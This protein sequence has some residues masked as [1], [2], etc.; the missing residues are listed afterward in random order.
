MEG[1]GL[2]GERLEHS[3]SPRIHQLLG[4]YEYRLMPVARADLPAFFARRAFRGINVTIPYKEAVIPY[5]DTLSP[6]ARAIG[7]VNTILQDP[8]G[9]LHGYNTD[10]DGFMALMR[11]AGFAAAGRKCLVLGSGGASKTVRACLRDLGAGEVVVIS[12]TGADNY[13][14]IG[15]HAD[16]QLIVNATPVGMYP[17]NGRA[18]LSLAGFRQLAG[19]VDLIYNPLRT[20]LLLEA[21]RLGI[22]CVNGLHMLVAQAKRAGE[23]FMG[24]AIGAGEV[25]RVRRTVEKEMSNIVLIGMPGSGKTTAARIIAKRLARR[26]IDTDA[27]VERRAGMRCADYLARFG[28]EAFRTL[29][30]EAVREAG[31]QTGCVIATGGGVVTRAENLPALRQNGV[32]FERWRPL[33]KLV[34]RNRPLSATPEKLAA[35][36][37]ARAPLYAQ[38]RDEMIKVEG[39]QEAAAEI[40]RRFEARFEGGDV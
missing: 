30:T 5:L 33:E 29:E 18:P 1:Y 25:F 16:A 7:S 14:N 39:A 24:R 26:M 36:Y 23:L 21:E 11:Q 20:A 10:Y 4:G 38:W 2:L 22:P 32:I 35:L 3:V 13:Q 12:R 27:L 19:V 9:A 17:D 37:A 31:R 8:Q 40:M 28:E 6:A 34:N 15:R